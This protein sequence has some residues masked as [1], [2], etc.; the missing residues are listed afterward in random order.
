MKKFIALLLALS[1][2]CGLSCAVAETTGNENLVFD[3]INYDS[4]AVSGNW[5][6]FNDLFYFN[7]PET[8]APVEVEDATFDQG[9]RFWANTPDNTEMFFLLFTSAEE[10]NGVGDAGTMAA[11]AE[12]ECTDVKL[13]LVNGIP[14]VCYTDADDIR[15]AQFFTDSGDAFALA[16]F[17]ASD[18]NVQAY[19]TSVL[20]S[21]TTDISSLGEDITVV[22][23]E[24]GIKL[25]EKDAFTI[26][27]D[28]FKGLLGV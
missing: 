13:A 27:V 24:K 16:F 19:M 28:W 26:V 12:A 5:Y 22:N 2:F 11:A 3:T 25:S 6:G 9:V 18:E 14:M 21:F 4:T 23:V 17:P 20:A 10:L 15:Y 8:W 7:L 1:L